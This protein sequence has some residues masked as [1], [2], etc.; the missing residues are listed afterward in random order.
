MSA[1]SP[2]QLIQR[3][4]SAQDQTA[5]ASFYRQQADR[6]WRYLVARG[7]NPE[8]AYDLLSETFFRFIR[9]VCKD[10]RSPLGFLYRIASNLQID[11]FRRRQARPEQ[12]DTTQVEQLAGNETDL[13]QQQ[14]VR[15]L[16]GRL[17]DFEQNLLLMRYWLGMSHKE[18]A[19]ALDIPEG[20]VRRKAAELLKVLGNQLDR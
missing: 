11:S 9:S 12:A 16:V 3:Y 6:L 8:D 17:P 13:D 1:L 19:A 18:I 7:S 2:R 10:P 15:E 5:L 20:S 4:C 14:L